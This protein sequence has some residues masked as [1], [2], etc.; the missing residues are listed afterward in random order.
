MTSHDQ[1]RRTG[2]TRTLPPEFVAWS[3]AVL[4]G[5]PVAELTAHVSEFPDL[6][7]PSPLVL[8]T[9][10]DGWYRLTLVDKLTGS[11]HTGYLRRRWARDRVIEQL[12]VSRSPIILR[13]R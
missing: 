6:T 9:D 3:A 11:S 13:R 4:G 8:T 2:R 12:G 5:H 7:V 10:E 1:P